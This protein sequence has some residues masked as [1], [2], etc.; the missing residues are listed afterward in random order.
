MLTTGHKSITKKK[1]IH[2]IYRA[3][4]EATCLQDKMEGLLYVLVAMAREAVSQLMAHDLSQYIP[5]GYVLGAE[6]IDPFPPNDSL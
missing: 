3:Q 4:N 6:T 1:P 5:E 2:R